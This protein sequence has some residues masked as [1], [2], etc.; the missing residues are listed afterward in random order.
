MTNV[1]AFS[2]MY[3]LNTN[4]LADSVRT[5]SLGNKGAMENSKMTVFELQK[6][7]APDNDS[8]FLIIYLALPS[9]WNQEQQICCF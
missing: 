1:C 3:K 5:Q 9:L 7:L 4:T 8:V 2:K 6:G